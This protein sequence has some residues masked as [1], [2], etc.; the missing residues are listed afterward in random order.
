MTAPENFPTPKYAYNN[1]AY[2]SFDV[3]SQTRQTVVGNSTRVNL[4][5]HETL[6]VE[7]EIQQ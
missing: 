2:Y 5:E 7:K 3:D 1:S 6:E 4:H